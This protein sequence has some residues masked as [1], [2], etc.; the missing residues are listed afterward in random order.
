[1]SDDD[2]LA[3]E[4]FMQ[5]MLRD[6]TIWYCMAAQAC[7]T[8]S[9]TQTKNDRMMSGKDWIMHHLDGHH[10]LCYERYRLS[11]TNFNILCDELKAKGLECNGHVI[12]EEQVAMFL[13][14]VG[15]GHVMR[16]VGYD[17]QHSIETVWRCFRRV[18]SAIL[19]LQLDYIKTPITSDAPIPSKVAEGTQ[20]HAFKGALGAIDGTHIKAI[21]DGNDKFPERYRNRKG[22]LTQNVMAAVDF[23]G[24][25][26]AVVAG[27]EGS[28]HDNLILRKAVEDGFVVPT[29]RY[30]LVD[31][32]Y[33]NT[34]QFL[35]PYRATLYHLAS[36][37]NR[38]RGGRNHYGCAE[39]L[40]NH[41]HS[42]LRNIV[43]KTFGILKSRFR[44]LV[45]MH[46]YEFKIQTDIV[47]ACCIL[48][49]FIKK[50]NRLQGNP[51]DNIFEERLNRNRT[52][53]SQPDEEDSGVP[54]M[55]IG[56]NLRDSIRDILWANRANR[57]H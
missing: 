15:H 16:V 30:Y 37:R 14:A 34:P 57:Q 13:Q 2:D 50:H 5:Q 17:F 33:A 4:E 47:I 25:F 32:G 36:F 18:L 1:M 20:F 54:N 46:P 21:P 45:D 52:C 35:S 53:N 55:Q 51:E 9:W 11:T 12:L 40:F 27:W 41:K 42:Q 28:A 19:L 23:D 29:G 39:E 6:T 43:E 10:L 8:I 3:Q 56:N 49:N 26:V 31:G 38:R 48:H 7:A 22:N 24:N 44:I